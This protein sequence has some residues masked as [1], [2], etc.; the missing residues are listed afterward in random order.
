MNEHVAEPPARYWSE[1]TNL[2]RVKHDLIRHYLGGWFPKLIY[3]GARK[4]VYFDTH[5]GG[6][7]I[8]VVSSARHWSH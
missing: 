5:A 6:D 8:T 1:Y 7:G 4:V 3:G 2:Q